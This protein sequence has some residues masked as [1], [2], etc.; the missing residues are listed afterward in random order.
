MTAVRSSRQ[1][2]GLAGLILAGSLVACRKHPS[3]DVAREIARR[4][5]FAHE[6]IIDAGASRAWAMSSRSDVLFEDGFSVL[7]YDP[8][9]N[10]LNH[11]FRW[12]SATNHVRLKSHGARPM[13]LFMHGWNDPKALKTRPEV[14]AY[15]DGQVV[16]TTGTD[17]AGLWGLEVIVQPEMLQ[18]TWVDLTITLSAVA[19]HWIDAP[20]LKVA[21]L[22]GLQW[23]ETGRP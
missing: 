15:I 4:E 18:N 16:G 14:T 7:M 23:D 12:M 17:E 5:A 21:M 9:N 19:F 1:L 20:Y 22:N 6:L 8:P 11:A 3:A 10:F 13:R 2:R